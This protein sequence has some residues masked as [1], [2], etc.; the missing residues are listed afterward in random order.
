CRNTAHNS[1][2]AWIAGGGES[3]SPRPVAQSEA[4]ALREFNAALEAAAG[5]LTPTR[6]QAEV[7]AERLSDPILLVQGPPGTRTTHTLAWAILGRAYA[8]ADAGRSFH[9]LVTAMTHTAVEVVLRSIADKLALLDGDRG[10]AH[11]AETLSG[12]R[13]FKE[14]STPGPVPEGVAP[15]DR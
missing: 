10:A 2:L 13:L 14:L 12:L 15:A 3:V 7:I 6:R 5:I 11:L 4:D 8:G 1:F 9:V